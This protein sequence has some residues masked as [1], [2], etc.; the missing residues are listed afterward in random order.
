MFKLGPGFTLVLRSWYYIAKSSFNF[1][2][3]EDVV[4]Y[5][6]CNKISFHPVTLSLH[7]ISSA[8]G[9]VF[10]SQT[11]NA[12]VAATVTVTAQRQLA[13]VNSS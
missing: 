5:R 4:G 2:Y 6:N 3:G 11:R 1:I 9:T 7:N 10:H 12:I 13:Y 8:R